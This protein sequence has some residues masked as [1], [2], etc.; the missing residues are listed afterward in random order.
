VLLYRLCTLFYDSIA[1]YLLLSLLVKNFENR[2]AFG[3]VGGKNS[4][5]FFSVDTVYVT[6][7]IILFLSYSHST[8]VSVFNSSVFSKC[9]VSVRHFLVH[10]VV[11]GMFDCFYIRHGGYVIVVCLSDC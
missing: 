11:S 5:S 9:L 3:K 6:V 4:V 7:V 1:R 2:L 10:P 8:T